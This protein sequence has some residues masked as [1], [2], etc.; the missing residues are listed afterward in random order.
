VPLKELLQ[1]NGIDDSCKL[2]LH[3]M[4]NPRRLSNSPS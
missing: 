2:F 3:G 1:I 4:D